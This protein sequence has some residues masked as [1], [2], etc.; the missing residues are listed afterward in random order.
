MGGRCVNDCNERGKE[1]LLREKQKAELARQGSQL[2]A[3]MATKGQAKKAEQA[4]R[5]DEL[6]R[7]FAEAESLVAERDA[8]KKE[9][10]ALEKEALDVYR[11]R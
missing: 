5:L 1:D 9:A 2:K 4:G 3:E 11:V 10:E 7:S 6:K 8:I